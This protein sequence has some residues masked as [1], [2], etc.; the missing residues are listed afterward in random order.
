[1]KIKTARHRI[2]KVMLQ[3][4]DEEVVIRDGECEIGDSWYPL[5]PMVMINMLP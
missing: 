4:A 3:W 1:M 2:Y 5:L